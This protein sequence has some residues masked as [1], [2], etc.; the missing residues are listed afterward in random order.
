MKIK[1]LC[2]V[3]LMLVL[4]WCNTQPPIVDNLWEEKKQEILER[5]Y[6]LESD[7]FEGL[8]K[9]T[10][11]IDAKNSS[12]TDILKE[13]LKK[14][15][16]TKNKNTSISDLEKKDWSISKEITLDDKLNIPDNNQVK[17]TEK[18]IKEKISN[19][20]AEYNSKLKKEILETYEKSKLEAIKDLENGIEDEYNKQIKVIDIEIG[21]YKWLS[22]ND[23]YK[24]TKI[25]IDKL[26]LELDKYKKEQLLKIDME[27]KQG[28]KKEYAKYNLD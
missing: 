27:I 9:I 16:I 2:L 28:I 24:Y 21:K 23:I 4:A 3:G 13:K 1:F 15:S 19:Q 22:Q 11:N 10:R 25:E 14:T 7:F 17:K 8:D 12:I 6:I 18:I 5:G 26:R 20:Q